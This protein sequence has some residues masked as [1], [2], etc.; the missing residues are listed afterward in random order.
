MIRRRTSTRILAVVGSIALIIGVV[1][2]PVACRPRRSFGVHRGPTVEQV[3]E[4]ISS[5]KTASGQLAKSDPALLARTDTTMISVMAKLDVDAAGS[6]A[7]DVRGLA[8]TSPQIT[9][10]TLS[11]S[12]PAVAKYLRHVGA[13]TAEATDAIDAALPAATVTASFP[14]AYGGIAVP[15]AGQPGEGPAEGARCGCGATGQGR[16][17]AHRQHP[18]VHRRHQGVAE[19][20]RV[21]HR[22]QGRHRRGDRHR[23]LARASHRSRTPACPP[24]PAA[25]GLQLRYRGHRPG[26]QVHLQR[27][28]DRRLRLPRH[29]RAG[30]RRQCRRLLQRRRCLLRAGQRRPRHPHRDPPLRAAR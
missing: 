9:G 2:G 30:Q 24:R 8:A 23:D 27:Q 1:N 20:R 4:P 6:Y 25:L 21:P 5:P 17:D 16:A 15:A 3:G 14:I 19:S 18:G 22:R 13:Q 29:Q 12:D 11:K 26:R 28:T 10:R 7:G